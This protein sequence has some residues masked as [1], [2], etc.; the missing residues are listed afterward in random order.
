MC[1]DGIRNISLPLSFFTFLH[2]WVTCTYI[3]TRTLSRYV[4]V[5]H[6]APAHRDVIHHFTSNTLHFS[7][8]P[9]LIATFHQVHHATAPSESCEHRFRFTWQNSAPLCAFFQAFW[10]AFL[11]GCHP[12]IVCVVTQ[13]I[14]DSD[15]FPSFFAHLRS[16][17]E[18]EKELSILCRKILENQGSFVKGEND[19][20]LFIESVFV[21]MFVLDCNTR[22]TFN[23]F[24]IQPV[25]KENSFCYLRTRVT[26][27]NV[28]KILLFVFIKLT[29]NPK[30]SIGILSL[31][32]S[33]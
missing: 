24:R 2:P 13:L 16:C 29:L 21:V 28:I 32:S 30:Q 20:M 25:A 33:G 15:R 18:T 9:P 4:Y 12:C 8:L 11:T 31:A 6:L 5:L 22:K 17:L 19:K 26:S 3:N 1:W 27:R 7:H 10:V 23:T 14:S